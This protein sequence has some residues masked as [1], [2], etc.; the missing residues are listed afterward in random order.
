MREIL[1][2]VMPHHRHTASRGRYDVPVRR[3]DLDK[4][5]GERLGVG[6]ASGVGHR[7]PT[8]GLRLG[9]IHGDAKVLE[10]LNG[11]H[12]HLR[13]KLVDV[14]GDEEADR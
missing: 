3:E 6:C 11:R 13:I 9:K 7:L 4:S 8:T 5:A 10:Q 1:V 12:P 2:V 14:A